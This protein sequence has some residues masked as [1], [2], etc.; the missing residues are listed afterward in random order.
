MSAAEE[1]IEFFRRESSA[2]FARNFA[3]K[4]LR[5]NPFSG[6]LVYCDQPRHKT[7]KTNYRPLVEATGFMLCRVGDSFNDQ[8]PGG[9]VR[10]SL[11]DKIPFEAAFPVPEREDFAIR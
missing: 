7:F 3:G 9:T 2:Y 4:N 5:D 10:T 8:D 6:Y 11:F 1:Q